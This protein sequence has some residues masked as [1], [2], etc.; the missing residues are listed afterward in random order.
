MKKHELKQRWMEVLC[1]R[2]DVD[3]EKMRED[4][5]AFLE[6]FEKGKQHKE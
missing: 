4:Y 3:P 2:Q 6:R 1:D 5:E